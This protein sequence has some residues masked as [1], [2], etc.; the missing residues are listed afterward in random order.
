MELAVTSVCADRVRDGTADLGIIPVVEMRRQELDFLR[1]TGIA[2]DGA[3]RSILLIS[4]V[5]F[6]RI[7]TLAADTSSRTSVVL[8]QVVLEQRYGVRPAVTP[9]RP[10]LDAMLETADAALIIGDPA[11]HLEPAGLPLAWLDLGAEWK[12]MTGLPFVFAVW[13][14][15]PEYLSQPWERLFLDSLEYGLERVDEIVARE[16]VRRNVPASL[17]KCYLTRYIQFRLGD[18]HYSG[19]ERF[20]EYARPYL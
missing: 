4:K 6:G 20:L 12:Q 10:D 19:M 11:L 15:R 8:S 3:V 14:G 5:P 18:R 16:S 17:A 7:R 1:G 9:H 2:C 13:A